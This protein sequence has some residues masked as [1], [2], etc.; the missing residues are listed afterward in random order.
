MPSLAPGIAFY[1]ALLALMILVVGL[2]WEPISRASEEGVDRFQRAPTAQELQ[3]E[4]V[5]ALRRMQMI[6]VLA[7]TTL[8]RL[9]LPGM[10][11]RKRG[12]IMNLASV[13]GYQ[14]GGPRMAGNL[15][16]W[17]ERRDGHCGPR[18]LLPR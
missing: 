10:L 7:L 13:V 9:A 8:T 17:V 18:P 12:R 6:N 2:A 5:D 1:G 4:S 16:E 14:P 3:N 15:S 11:E